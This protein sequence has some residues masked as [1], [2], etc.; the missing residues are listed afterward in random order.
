MWVGWVL[1]CLYSDTLYM[2]CQV[3]IDNSHY[4]VVEGGQFE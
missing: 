3:S 1:M 2:Y 4:D